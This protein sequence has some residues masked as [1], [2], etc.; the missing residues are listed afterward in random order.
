MSL[1]QPVL[2]L[3]DSFEVALELIT[4]VLT[5]APYRFDSSVGR[6]PFVVAIGV[7]QVI[8]GTVE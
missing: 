1:F 2:K 3:F 7:G 6:G 5:P 8:K 4:H